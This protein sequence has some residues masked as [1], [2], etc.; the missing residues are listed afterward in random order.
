M[1]ESPRWL[2][3]RGHHI[4]ARHILNR[5]TSSEEEATIQ[6]NRIAQAIGMTVEN[7]NNA[8]VNMQSTGEGVW[9]DLLLHP[10][11]IVRHMLACA[12]GI[13]FFQ[14][15]CGIDTLVLYS[16]R[17]FEKAKI[18]SSNT[19]LIL[20]I[21]IQLLKVVPILVPTFCLDKVGRKRLLLISINGMIFGLVFLGISLTVLD[22]SDTKPLWAVRM[23]IVSLLIC[24]GFYSIGMGPIPSVYSSE[25]F[26]LRLRAQGNAISAGFG[27]VMAII[28]LY[29]Y[30]FITLGGVAFVFMAIGLLACWFV[31]RIMPESQ[32]RTLE[33]MQQ[34]FG[35]LNLWRFRVEAI[36]GQT[37]SDVT[38]Q[39]ADIEAQP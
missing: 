20:T 8:Q 28:I 38:A 2:V 37:N 17:I 7:N 24:V 34:I 31:R 18:T 19:K 32:G 25:I 16:P 26:P 29:L 5:I 3:M 39:G 1:L 21:L 11:P 14:Q 10:I 33:E 9:R 13:Y 4:E 30:E 22:N 35:S 6:L 23:C 27:G 12:I 15:G 36:E